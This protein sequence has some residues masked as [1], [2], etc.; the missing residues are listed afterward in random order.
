MSLGTSIRFLVQRTLR[1]AGYEIRRFTLDEMHRLRLLLDSHKVD[2]VLDVGANIGQ[3]ASTLRAAG[4][5]GTIISFEPQSA[6]HSKLVALAKSDP[7]WIVAPR[8]AVGAAPGEITMN[9][10]ANSVSSSALPILDAHT[11][12]APSSRY[13][14]QETATVIRLD[15]SDLVP[16]A[17]RI[18]V[19]IDTQGFEGEVIKGARKVLTRAVGVQTELSLAQLYDG[20]PDYLEILRDLTAL[21][22]EPWSI[23]PGF[24]DLHSHRLL[25]MDATLFRAASASE[26]CLSV[27]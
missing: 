13:V 17:D 18:F 2:T 21:G 6:A 25:Q 3:F 8:A 11:G 26:R 7:K 27:A 10:S 9:I 19:K 24:A 12:S 5:T 23:E 20:Q 14:S 22:F 15:D 16:A 4:F 1:S